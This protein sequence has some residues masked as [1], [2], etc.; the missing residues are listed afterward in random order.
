MR[1]LQLLLAMYPKLAMHLHTR[2]SCTH[3]GVEVLPALG[4]AARRAWLVDGTAHIAGDM[5][6][7]D[8]GQEGCVG[9]IQGLW[10]E[11]GMVRLVLNSLGNMYVM[12]VVQVPCMPAAT[13]ASCCAAP[14][15][16][17]LGRLC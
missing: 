5:H 2:G 10:Q 3:L 4:C 6:I 7:V 12:C 11:A 1:K 9:R 13:G 15:G 17:K 14:G 8:R 16:S